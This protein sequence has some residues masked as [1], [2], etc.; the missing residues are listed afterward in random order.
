MAEP[1]G[2]ASGL[3]ALATFAFQSSVSLYQMVQ[4]YQDLP[5]RVRDLNEEL[6]SLNEVLGGLNE[7]LRF[8]SGSKLNT[9]ECPLFWCGSACQGFE[10]EIKKCSTP[11]SGGRKSFRDW[12]KI[13][14]MGQ[15]IDGFRRMMAG[16]K[17]TIIIALTDANL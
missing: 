15:D 4:S 9:L 8:N 3:V 11:S 12:A 7:I 17:S 2:L 5:K 10:E 16:Y 14:Y 6:Q 13:R 1:I